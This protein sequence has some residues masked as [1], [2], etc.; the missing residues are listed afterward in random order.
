MIADA[1]DP[2][3]ILVIKLGAL[4]DFIY[5]L[6]PMAAIR[7]NHSNARIS[8]LTTKPFEKLGRDCGYFD[9]IWI[10]EKPKFNPLSWLALKNRLN[11]A[12]FNR[13]YDLQNNERT[14]RYFTL[15]HP[16][17]EW[18]GVAIGASH[19]NTS[20]ERTKF[21]A[22]FGHV[23]TLALAGIDDVQLDELSWMTG[24]IDVATIPRPYVLLVPG[25]S[26]Q[27]PQK[28]WPVKHYRV[29]AEKMLA[30]G[31]HP[32]VIGGAA[33]TELAETICRNLSCTNLAGKT[34]LEDLPQLARDAAGAVGNDTGPMHIIAV[35]GCPSLML[36]STAASNIQKHG[37]LGARVQAIEIMDLSDLDPGKVWDQFSVIGASMPQDNS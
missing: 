19:R 12:G 9:E 25:S 20:P 34:K 36:F 16:Q 21:N 3:K 4:G 6:G 15:F 18:V 17:P 14:G 23:Q 31:L 29:L 28:R 24:R 35:T 10:D 30:A 7:K 1:A 33:E 8:L 26:P 37:P 13:V 5:A 32:V 2:E 22:Y 11:R 27:H